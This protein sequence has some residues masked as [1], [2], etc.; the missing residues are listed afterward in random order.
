MCAM[1]SLLAGATHDKG[2]TKF[3]GDAETRIKDI[4]LRT[5]ELSAASARLNGE[6]KNLDVRS[7]VPL[8][9]IAQGVVESL[10][11]VACG[12]IKKN[13]SF[14]GKLRVSSSV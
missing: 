11:N 3:I 5:E 4:T 9:C 14:D 8:H 6:I 1:I 13:G 2:K 10:F 12:G 7:H